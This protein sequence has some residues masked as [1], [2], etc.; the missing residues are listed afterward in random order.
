MINFIESLRLFL[1]NTQLNFLN[2]F[3]ILIGFINSRKFINLI[4]L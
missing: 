4:I 2:K 1:M 3:N